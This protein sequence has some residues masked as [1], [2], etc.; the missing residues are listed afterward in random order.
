MR[1]PNNDK[2]ADANWG[3]DD[4]ELDAFE[5]MTMKNGDDEAI[6]RICELGRQAS[7]ANA[8]VELKTLLAID[9]FISIRQAHRLF[10]FRE[11]DGLFQRVVA[12]VEIVQRLGELRGGFCLA[13]RFERVADIVEL[14][15]VMAVVVEHIAEQ[16]EGLFAAHRGSLTVGVCVR[17]R[18]AVA[19]PVGVLVDVVV[20]MF[21]HGIT[22]FGTRN[23]YMD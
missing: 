20:F 23:I 10:S 16:G 3:Y 2:F 9:E 8:Y 7:D 12:V 21:V 1:E 4:E 18:M 22:P 14:I 11:S 19:V 6:R 5:N 17:V 15:G 13:A